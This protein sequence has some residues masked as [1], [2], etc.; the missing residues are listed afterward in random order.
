M[1]GTANVDPG[2]QI[3]ALRDALRRHLPVSDHEVARVGAQPNPRAA[4]RR[5][6]PSTHR[7][8]ASAKASI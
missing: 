2:R 1:H 5:S 3:A 6:K 8:L 7:P 4:W